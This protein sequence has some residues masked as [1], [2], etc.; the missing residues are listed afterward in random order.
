MGATQIVTDELH[1]NIDQATSFLENLKAKGLVHV[2][3]SKDKAVGVSKFVICI[4]PKCGPSENICELA[5]FT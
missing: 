3:C 2:V 5:R 4:C 1:T